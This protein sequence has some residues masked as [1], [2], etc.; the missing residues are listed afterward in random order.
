M[1]LAERTIFRRKD[2]Q[3]FLNAGVLQP[4][5]IA[6]ASSFCQERRVKAISPMEHTPAL[7]ELLPYDPASK[8]EVKLKDGLKEYLLLLVAAEQ[9][10]EALQKGNL[11]AFDP[12]V[13]EN[14]C[15]IR[16]VKLALMASR[17]SFDP[18]TLLI[19]LARAK[20]KTEV[21]L[22][23]NSFP[24]GST[25]KDFL[26]REEMKIKM[27]DNELFLIESFILSKIKT[28]KAFTKELPLALHESTDT[29]KLREFH[30]V[31]RFFANE[32]VQ[33]LRERISMKSV[34]FVQKLAYK[35]PSI[36]AEMVSDD[37][38]INYRGL[39]CIPGYWTAQIL[40]EQAFK[41]GIP[42]VLLANQ[43]AQ[44]QD[45]QVVRQT[46]LFFQPTEKGYQATSASAFDPEQPALVIVGTTCR[47]FQ[48][49]PDLEAWKTELMKYCPIELM[50]AATAIHRQ[51]PDSSKEPMVDGIQDEKYHYYKAKAHEW[52]CSAENPSRIFLSHVFCDKIKNI[53]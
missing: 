2:S 12:L 45:Y 49:L 9:A 7:S 22:Q 30:N 46:T 3:N 35:F 13:G 43:K 23:E 51:Y 10:M 53:N 38:S 44:D 50:L 17:S 31:S 34:S 36:N 18:D 6:I 15:Q 26:E 42:I 16:A 19:K 8:A 5:F 37:F 32:L 1:K 29:K 52:G 28:P 11:N 27:H 25:L 20:K 21:L 39:H 47:D 24:I 48:S 40:M 14:A 33:F 41:N 4:A